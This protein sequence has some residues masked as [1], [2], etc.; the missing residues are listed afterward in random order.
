MAKTNGRPATRQQHELLQES[1]SVVEEGGA[2]NEQKGSHRTT[3]KQRVVTTKKRKK[4]NSIVHRQDQ[5]PE[6]P[7]GR[8][9][10]KRT[11]IRRIVADS[12]ASILESVGRAA[13]VKGQEKRRSGPDMDVY[14][15]DNDHG[16]EEDGSTSSSCSSTPG[17]IN[18]DCVN[19]SNVDHHD[20]VSAF[21]HSNE[22]NDD[23]DNNEEEEEEDNNGVDGGVG[24]VD[25]RARQVDGQAHGRADGRNNWNRGR[26]CS[27]DVAHATRTI[28]STLMTKRHQHPDRRQHICDRIQLYV[29][30][31]LF[32]K[33]KFIKNEDMLMELMA[34]VER[35]EKFRDQR[36]RDAFKAIY[37][38]VVMEAI[39]IRRS[40]C[41][42][43]GGRIVEQY[44]SSN[45]ATRMAD[46]GCNNDSSSLLDIENLSFFNLET[47]CKLR[48]AQTADEVKAFNWFFGE[49]M[50]CVSGKRVWS[51]HKYHTLISEAVNRD[52]GVQII[53]VSDEAFGLL[54]LENYM[55]K[56]KRKFVAKA[57][58]VVLEKK[59]DGKFTA[60][61]KGNFVFGGWSKA[62]Q[63]Q[64]NFYVNMVKADR[65]G[66]GARQMETNFLSH[67]Q[68]TPIGQKIYDK[69]QSRMSAA[70][71]RGEDSA[72]ESDCDVYI[73][74]L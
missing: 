8:P 41:D 14:D 34:V 35:T 63:K 44:L 70:E 56:W 40:A 55:E 32:R 28:S 37:K 52:T 27:N 42:Q 54:L 19:D 20:N 4:R 13:G 31:H 60:S 17:R 2:T 48:R 43:A 64:F 57:N 61:T 21:S 24:G 49:F 73:E 45:L 67:M 15:C 26:N 9:S 69:M 36:S 59:L 11:R 10:T 71:R 30:T 66:A 16:S 62:G 29:K 6:K 58:G 33:V 1:L 12:P 46:G 23:E 72:V 25:G 39:N 74:P 53:T 47:F 22:D 18:L 3:T 68:H 38:G 50:D 65:S 7:I 5:T 51:R